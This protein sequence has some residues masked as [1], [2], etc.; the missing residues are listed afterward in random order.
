MKHPFVTFAVLSAVLAL[1]TG[2]T[3]TR[4]T[5]TVPPPAVSSASSAPT[6]APAPAPA[7]QQQEI[8][9]PPVTLPPEQQPK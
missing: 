9:T 6:P 5:T 2:C 8:V 1:S 7:T 4:E 3:T